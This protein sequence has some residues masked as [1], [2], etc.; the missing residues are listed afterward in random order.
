MAA[1]STA[2]VFGIILVIYFAIAGSQGLA[3]IG[4]GSFVAMAMGVGLLLLPLIGIYILF[5]EMQFGFRVQKM[6]REL[7]AEGG[8]PV[9]DLPRTAG[10]AVDRDAADQQFEVVKSITEKDPSD[11]RA[12]YG[13]AASYDAASDRKRARAAMRYAI[14]L[15]RG[16]PVDP[17]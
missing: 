4:T 8:L 1:R 16:D 3:L 11:W 15:H 14:A 10:G 6:A 13:L 17:R 12:W 2:I 7:E 5:R 9:D